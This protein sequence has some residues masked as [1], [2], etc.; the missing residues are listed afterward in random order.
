[1]RGKAIMQRKN[2]A[3]E[4]RGMYQS[5]NERAGLIQCAYPRD[6][7][8]AIAMHGKA[9]MQEDM[10]VMSVVLHPLSHRAPPQLVP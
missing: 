10:L 2:V 6:S 9:Q 1:M 3:N 4:C 8:R 5:I 7:G